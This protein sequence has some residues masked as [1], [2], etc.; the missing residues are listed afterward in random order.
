MAAQ[1]VVAGLITEMLVTYAPCTLGADARVLPIRSEWAV[2][3]TAVNGEFACVRWRL[4]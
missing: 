2:V 4:R 1:F 3:E